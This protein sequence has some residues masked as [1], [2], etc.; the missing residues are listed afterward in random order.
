[1]KTKHDADNPIELEIQNLDELEKD[2]EELEFKNEPEYELTK[3][4]FE[5]L[6]EGFIEI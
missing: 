4:D 2:D 1:M 5:L 3:E 6:E